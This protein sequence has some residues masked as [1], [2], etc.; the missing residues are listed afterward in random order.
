MVELNYNWNDMK[1]Y[2]DAEAYWAD[3]EEDVKK[4]VSE[5]LHL[6]WLRVTA[7]AFRFRAIFNEVTDTMPAALLNSMADE[8]SDGLKKMSKKLHDAGFH[9]HESNGPEVD[10][11][12]IGPMSG[13]ST[14]DVLRQIAEA[15]GDEELKRRLD[16]DD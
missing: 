12:V 1:S 15:T 9:H 13:T 3:H 16:G 5:E 7:L 14:K 4:S 11:K 2:K 6:E 8:V 10:V